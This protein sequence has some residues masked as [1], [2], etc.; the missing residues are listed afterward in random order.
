MNTTVTVVIAGVLLAGLFGLAAQPAVPPGHPPLPAGPAAPA[1]AEADVGSIDAVIAAYYESVSGP[2]G[3]PRDWD[4]FRSLFMPG[5]RFVTSRPTATGDA[6]LTLTPDQF[7]QF[8]QK[9]FEQGGYFEK[10]VYS[11][12]DAFGHIAQVFSTYETRRRQDA[13]D[14]YSRG[15]NS[16]QLLHSNGR[17]WIVTVMWD[18]ERPG[19]EPIPPRYLPAAPAQGGSP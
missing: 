13:A 19:D 6:P 2:A 17:W 15:V 1:A 14:P 7:I 9:Y 18:H 10:Q 8:N 3:T 4:R 12:V 16:I 11:R 5:A